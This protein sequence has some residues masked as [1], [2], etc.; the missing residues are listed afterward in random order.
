MDFQDQRLDHLWTSRWL[1]KHFEMQ[2]DKGEEGRDGRDGL[3]GESG[4]KGNR[5]HPGLV[6]AEGTPVKTSRP[7]FITIF[8][9]GSARS[10]RAGW[11]EGR[12][13]GSRQLRDTRNTRG[14]WSRWDEGMLS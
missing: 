11:S 9:A 6:G 5:G 1:C 14:T 12:H 3:K 7:Y 2:G 8:A 10:K 13:R 4:S